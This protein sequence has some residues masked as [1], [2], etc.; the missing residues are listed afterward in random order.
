MTITIKVDGSMR[1]AVIHIDKR[2]AIAL[3]HKTGYLDG[4]EAYPSD[5]QFLSFMSVEAMIQEAVE[6]YERTT[7]AKRKAR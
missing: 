6:E 1:E 3:G 4:R 2:D 7:T 5:V